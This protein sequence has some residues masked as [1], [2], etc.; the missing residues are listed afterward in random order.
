MSLPA[1]VTT[2]P[3]TQLSQRTPGS[4]KT[5]DELAIERFGDPSTLA[6]S[7][8]T[9]LEL[10]QR[11]ASEFGVGD[12]FGEH[13]DVT[14]ISVV[15][16]SSRM[17]QAQLLYGIEK[18]K[19]RLMEESGMDYAEATFNIAKG[20]AHEKVWAA[21]DRLDRRVNAYQ[22]SL[23]KVAARIIGEPTDE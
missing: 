7:G 2:T 4:L 15:V 16:A 5:L 22:S 6:T 9:V 23:G 8:V 12:L 13:P 11:Y 3:T 17:E 1:L 19:E 20:G 14:T 21:L 18:D 10:A